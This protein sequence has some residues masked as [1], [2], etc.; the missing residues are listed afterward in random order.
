[1]KKTIFVALAAVAML[2]SCGAKMSPEAT[3]AWNDFKEKAAAVST[4]EACDQFETPEAY[5]EAFDAAMKAGQDF[6]KNFDGKVTKEVADSCAA[7]TNALI[8]HDKK[9]QEAIA[10]EKALEEQETAE[11]ELPEEGEEELEAQM[12]EEEVEE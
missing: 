7:L 6:A 10:A 5:Q 2:V 3:K 1:M 8:E 12:T 11:E 9:V 4:D